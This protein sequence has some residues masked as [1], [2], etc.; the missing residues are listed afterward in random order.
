MIGVGIVGAGYFG[1]MHAEAIAEIPE[2]RLVAAARTNRAALDEFTTRFKARGYVSYLDLLADREVEVVVIATPHHLHTD[3]AVAA[4]AAGKHILLEK[5]MAP[6]LGEC[7]GILRAVAEARVKLMVGHVNHFARAYRVA[8][9]LLESGEMGEVVLGQSTMAKFWFEANRR[10]WHLDRATGGGMF[11]TA[12]MHC[13]D[14]LTWLVSS[15]VRSVCAH[16]ATRFHDQRADDV[17]MLFLRYANGAVGTV[18]ST[19]YR[20]GTPKHL[21]ELTCTKGMLSI[22]YVAGV[23]IGRDERWHTVPDSGS[24]TWMHEALVHEWRGFLVALIAGTEPPV[25]G[26]FARH[27]MA[28]AFAAE[29]SSRLEQEVSVQ[30]TW[31]RS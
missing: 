12:G 18:V 29:E 9:A 16:F 15:P 5:P 23:S 13:L 10:P 14:R 20:V 30:D 11:L 3:I 25:S 8:N 19:G 26:G 22:D 28:T 21:T 1:A 2:L 24:A 7:D 4:A 27:I 6:S 31:G 17:G